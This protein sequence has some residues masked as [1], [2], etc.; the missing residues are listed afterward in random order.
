V[1]FNSSVTEY[2]EMSGA[3]T[4]FGGIVI[5]SLSSARFVCGGQPKS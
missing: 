2:M 3:L 4:R 1:Q 5:L